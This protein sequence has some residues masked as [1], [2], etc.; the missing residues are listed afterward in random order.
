MKRLLTL[1]N[2]VLYQCTLAAAAQS[3]TPEPG[4]KEPADSW[5]AVVATEREKLDGPYKVRPH[6]KLGDETP[7]SRECYRRLLKYVRLTEPRFHDWPAAAGCRYHKRDDHGEHGV[8]QNTTVALGYSVLLA[9]KYDESIAGTPRAKITSNLVSLLRYIAI[10]HVA[11]FLPAGDCEPWGD[12]WQSAYW[13]SM[14]GHAAWLAWDLLD[15][16]VKVMIVR[17]VAHEADRFNTRP[18]DSGESNDTKSEENAWNSEVIALAD[19][20]LPKHPN[21]SLWH[22][23]AIVWMLNSFS[24]D[25]DKRDTHVVDGRPAMDRITA[26]N[27]HPDFTLENHGRVHPDYL[28]CV[29]LLLRNVLLYEGAGLIGVKIRDRF[30]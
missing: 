1:L 10:T 29:D 22:E 23:R 6:R 28:C 24:R 18:P 25:A 9:G 27:V 17:M 12:Q 21:A 8:R 16:D 26:A 19:C 2:L 7:L 15:D 11:N 14:A 20:M 3:Q 13:A 30:C 4:A 5:R